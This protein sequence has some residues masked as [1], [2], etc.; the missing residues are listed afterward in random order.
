MPNPN[1]IVG[2]VLRLEP[3]TEANVRGERAVILGGDQRARLDPNDAKSA[4][5]ARILEGLARLARP[6]YLEINPATG[7][8]KRF[9]IPDVSRVARFFPRDDG[10]LDV[11]LEM[12]HAIRRLNKGSSDFANFSELLRNS[13]RDTT[14]LIV[15]FE[16]DGTIIDV[17]GFRPGPDGDLPRFPEQKW[18]PLKWIEDLLRWIFRWPFWPWRWWW[19]IGCV[20]STRA[21]QIFDAMAATTCAPLT[22]PAPCV[23]FLYP[24]D[25]C[26]ARAH[27]MVRLMLAMGLHPK[28]VWIQG[29]PLHPSTKNHPNCS[30]TWGWHVAPTICVRTRWIFFGRR[31]VIDPALFT[32]PVSKATWKNVQNNPAATLTDTDGTYYN[33]IWSQPNDP[34]Y[35]DTN[36]YLNVYRL[37]LQSR[38]LQVGPPPY[39]NCP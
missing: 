13:E 20:S 19:W 5:F 24:D 2:R 7:F 6:V 37:A 31:M 33:W 10:S 27:E 38:S 15:T 18:P 30:V 29:Y 9:L 11:L 35:A 32:T 39:A 1:A 25:G 17:R 22:V 36:Y 14:A 34:G 4:G 26:W 8:I 16:V 23:P 12:S 21:Q 3:S 28:K